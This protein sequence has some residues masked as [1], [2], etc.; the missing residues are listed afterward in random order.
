MWTGDA[1][2]AA[3]VIGWALPRRRGRRVVPYH[4]RHITA[5]AAVA[6]APSGG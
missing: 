4:Y 1:A 3:A 2:A 5:A 6:P